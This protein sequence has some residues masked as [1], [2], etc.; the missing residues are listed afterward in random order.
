[1]PT[2]P[3]FFKAK[4]QDKTV[5]QQSSES[6]GIFWVFWANVSYLSKQ[7]SCKKGRGH[8]MPWFSGHWRVSGLQPV[9][10]LKSAL[11]SFL[12]KLSLLETGVFWQSR[13]PEQADL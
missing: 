11:P 12:D 13:S 7:N 6:S 9:A 8:Q 2:T 5:K 1:M 4:G 3:P 10:L